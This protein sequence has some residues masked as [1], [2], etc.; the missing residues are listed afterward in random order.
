[1]KLIIAWIFNF[2]RKGTQRREK[3]EE[4]RRRKKSEKKQVKVALALVFN[5]DG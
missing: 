2:Y 1:L 5:G 4:R 3:R